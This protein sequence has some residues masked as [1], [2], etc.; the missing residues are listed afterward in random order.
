MTCYAVGHLRN[1][2]MGEGIAA[3]L[4]G[5]DATLRPHGGRF[6]IH[7]GPKRMLEGDWPGD[8]IVIA[9]PGRAEAERW[10]GSPAYAEI[11]PLRRDHSEGEIFLID[12]V[13]RDHRATDILG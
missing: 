7:G 4:K 8:L 6:I 2:E 13:G 5:I 9:F 1:V 10:Y 11:L 3:Y 12:G